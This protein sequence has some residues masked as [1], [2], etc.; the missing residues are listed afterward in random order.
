MS[1]ESCA[2]FCELLGLLPRGGQ[3]LVADHM[4]AGF[5]EGPRGCCMGMIRRDDRDCVDAVL[6]PPLAAGHFVKVGVDPVRLQQQVLAGQ[7]G[8]LGIGRQGARNE[9]PAIVEA[10]RDAMHR[11]D[12]RAAPAA[13]HAEPQTPA[14]RSDPSI[15]QS[16]SL[17]LRGLMRRGRACDGW[18]LRRFRRR[19]NRRRLSP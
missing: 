12:E 11:A 13:H 2:S 10:R 16:S 9:F 6:E 1:P 3:R 8:A 7:P 15:L 19:R 5:Q 18:R 14:Q 17:S 4:D